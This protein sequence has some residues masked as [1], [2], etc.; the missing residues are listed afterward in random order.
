MM[1]MVG[2]WLLGAFVS[3]TALVQG[4]EWDASF[5]VTTGYR[6]DRITTDVNIYDPPGTFIF[7]DGLLAKHIQIWE[8]GLN[9][10]V[11]F[12]SD[13]F[14]KGFANF[15]KVH[16]GRYIET[17][18]GTSENE[19]ISKAHIS[20]GETRDFSIGVG[21]LY[22][23]YECFKA[24]VAGGWSYD[25]QRIKMKDAET[26]EVDDPVLDGLNYN[27]RWQGLWVGVEAL[28]FWN[29]FEFNAGYEYHWPHWHAEWLLAGPAVQTTAFSD[30]RHAK[31]GSGNVVF[32]DVSYPFFCYGEV[33]L[34]FKYQYWKAKSGRLF[35]ETVSFAELGFPNEVDRIPSATWQSFEV[36][37]S[38]GLRF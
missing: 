24:G 11:T 26:D 14:I 16:G 5:D 25:H 32:I 15:G 9:G 18:E 30:V 35:P 2:L 21:Y 12:C 20:G 4:F 31:E 19:F 22:P 38:L 13:F 8:V 28:Y 17:V 7:S 33:G 3:S 6:Q 10:R 37:A 29:C 27:N 34:G 1:R 23:F 36:Q